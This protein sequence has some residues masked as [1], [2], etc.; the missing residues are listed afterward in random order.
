[1]VVEMQVVGEHR[2]LQTMMGHHRMNRLTVAVAV[3]VALQ[4]RQ[5]RGRM[6]LAVH[7]L[8][9]RCRKTSL[10]ITKD[11]QPPMYSTA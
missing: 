4:T 6:L 1:M 5:A 8:I 10:S 7:L 9:M 2:L 11:M 3:A